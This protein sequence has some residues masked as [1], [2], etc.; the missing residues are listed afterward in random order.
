MKLLEG[1]Q[2]KGTVLTVAPDGGERY[3]SVYPE[4]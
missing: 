2:V 3:L 4:K 1:K